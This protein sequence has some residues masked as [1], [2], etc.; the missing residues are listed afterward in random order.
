MPDL[1]LQFG[2]RRARNDVDRA[3][4]R[5]AALDQTQNPH[6]T[7]GVIK[8]A[9]AVTPGQREAN[10][11]HLIFRSHHPCILDV[12]RELLALR[13]EIGID[14]MGDGAGEMADADALVE[15]NRA[16]PHRAV[17]LT[18]VQHLPEPHMMTAIGALAGRLFKSKVLAAAEVEDRKS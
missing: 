1:I 11:G 4:V 10:A 12:T 9:A 15:G 8:V 2:G 18:L 7:V 3:T 16:E 5:V 13:I 17:F 6:L 14:M